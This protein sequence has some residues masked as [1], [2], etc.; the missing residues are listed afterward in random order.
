MT[1]R[2][3]TPARLGSIEIS[4]RIVMAPMMRCRASRDGVP[5]SIMVEYYRQRASAGLIISEGVQ[6]SWQGQG[7]ARTP[8]IH[9]PDQIAA[10]KPIT[11]VVH[12]AGGKM[13]CQLMH[14]GRVGHPLN[15]YKPVGIIAPSAIVAPGTIHTDQR[16]AVPKPVP[17]EATIDD[18]NTLI[19]QYRHATECA[20]EA[21]FDGV[22]FHGANGYLGH[23]FLSTGSNQRDDDYG[24]SAEKRCRFVVEAVAAM[25]VVD[26]GDRIGIRVSPGGSPAYIPDDDPY[27]TYAT[28]FR[29]LPQDDLAWVHIQPDS[30]GWNP[31]PLHELVRAPLIL[32]GGYTGESAE[33]ALVN[34][35]AKAIGFG[36]PFIANPDLV[37]RLRHNRPLAS[38]DPATYFTPG[39]E[40]YLDY[41]TWEE[42]TKSGLVT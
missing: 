40:G 38:P 39:P 15:Q 33:D 24:G 9:T 18:I 20:F 27:E 23:Q 12:D 1:D 32:T 36:R 31:E 30:D 41:L 8:G 13:A 7:Y 21:G 29:L 19:E 3:F 26:G 34:T 10:W 42:Q 22:E 37:D 28:L 35:P 2:L 6:P 5:T 16:G 17:S 25:A 4:N 11:Q 14:V